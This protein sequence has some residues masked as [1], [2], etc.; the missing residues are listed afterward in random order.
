MSI[1]RIGDII[2]DR[3][4]PN[5]SRAQ[6]EE[7]LENLHRL[8]RLIIRVNARLW[9]DNPQSEIRANGG[10]EVESESSPNPV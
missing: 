7:A 9:R 3:Y 8:A 2:L 10:R 4:L 5:T 1:R 6:R